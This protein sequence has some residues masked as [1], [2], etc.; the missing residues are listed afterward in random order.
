VLCSFGDL[1]E[2]IRAKYT[3]WGSFKNLAILFV[4]IACLC[5]YNETMHLGNEDKTEVITR[6][7]PDL[8][9]GADGIT[10][11]VMRKTTTYNG[12]TMNS[13]EVGR[14][15][16]PKELQNLKDIQNEDAS[17][18]QRQTSRAQRQANRAQRQINHAVNQHVPI[19]AHEPPQHLPTWAQQAHENARKTHENARKTR[20]RVPT[21]VPRPQNT[22]RGGYA[23]NWVQKLE[24]EARNQEKNADKWMR[25]RRLQNEM[26]E[27]QPQQPQQL[28][29]LQ[30]SQK[31]ILLK[32]LSD[33]RDRREE[34]QREREKKTE[35][36]L[37]QLKR[38]N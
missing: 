15:L 21:W 29:Q 5:A 1:I 25:E 8:V 19:F 3:M 23:D 34:A 18:A 20:E 9:T 11:Q 36:R 7:F 22:Q 32:E 37:R 10:R 4:I 27:K 14:Y 6:E 30:Q 2:K 26:K 38:G 16:T 12:K 13:D 31:D 28:Q 17:H 24:K 33:A 35:E